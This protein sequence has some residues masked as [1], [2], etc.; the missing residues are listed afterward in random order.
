LA[1]PAAPVSSAAGARPVGSVAGLA[2]SDALKA[3]LEQGF[4]PQ[5][6][7]SG[8]VVRQEPA[9]GTLLEPGATIHLQLEPSS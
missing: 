5:M 8:R 3:L 4:I 2:A 1:S 7:G 9:A 6:V